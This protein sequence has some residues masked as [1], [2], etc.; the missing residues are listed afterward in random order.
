MQRTVLIALVSFLPLAT[1][2]S[3]A[4]AQAYERIE[5]RIEYDDIDLTHEA[6]ADALLDRIEYAARRECDDRFGRMSVDEHREIS[7]C[8][9]EFMR[10]AVQQV[11]Y[12]AVVSRYIARGGRRADV[13]IAS[14]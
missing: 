12:P 9:R 11:N 6:G 7:R 2:T 4:A 8:K 1:L 14:R 5:T 3:P 13:V 10:N